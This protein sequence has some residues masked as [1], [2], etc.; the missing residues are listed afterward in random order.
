[1]RRTV[2]WVVALALMVPPLQAA[3]Q[4]PK[5][6]PAFCGGSFYP[7]AVDEKGVAVGSAGTTFGACVP[8]SKMID[9]KEV[10]VPTVPAYPSASVTYRV[11]SDGTWTYGTTTTDKDG[12]PT[13]TP[14]PPRIIK[15]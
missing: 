1:M 11:N 10:M 8:I 3:A 12:K 9:G 6:E 13:F 14:I 5:P 7:P 4:G 15:K 2:G